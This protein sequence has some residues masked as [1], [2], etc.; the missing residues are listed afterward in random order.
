MARKK[1]NTKYSPV[2]KLSVIQDMREHGL[3]YNETAR[4]YWSGQPSSRYI[5]SVRLWEHTFSLYVFLLKLYIQ[6]LLFALYSATILSASASIGAISSG[7]CN[8]AP[9]VN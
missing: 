9:Q 4:K 1:I 8:V 7:L 6:P 2:F 3:G 5:P